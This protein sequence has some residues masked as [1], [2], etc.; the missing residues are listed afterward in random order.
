VATPKLAGL[1]SGMPCERPQ[2]PT[3]IRIGNARTAGPIILRG[4]PNAH[5]VEA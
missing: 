4:N 2:A 3:P 5:L 1:H